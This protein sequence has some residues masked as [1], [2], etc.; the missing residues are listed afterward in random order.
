MRHKGRITEWRDDQ[1]FGFVA[2]SFGGDRVFLHIKAFAR[3]SR[4]PTQGDLVTY[5]LTFDERRRP[6]ASSVRFSTEVVTDAG[7]PRPS[8][9]SLGLASVFVIAVAGVVLAGRLPAAVLLLY[10]GTSVVA[11]AAYWLDKSAARYGR[12]RTAESTL[13]VL[14]LAGGWPGALFAQRVFRHKSRKAE[15]QRVFWVTV[16]VNCAGLGWLLTEKGSAFLARL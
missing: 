5:E 11:F 7:R 14:G 3:R 10:L 16:I 9:I 6:R 12:S 1:G 2:P 4:R 15:F 8:P 13:H